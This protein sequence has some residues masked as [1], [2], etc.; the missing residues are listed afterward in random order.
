M[1]DRYT[2]LIKAVNDLSAKYPEIKG[3][4]YSIYFWKPNQKT[5]NIIFNIAKDLIVPKIKIPQIDRKVWYLI[6]GELP[7]N[8][9][10]LEAIVEKLKGLK[11]E[12]RILFYKSDYLKENNFLW[13]K[14][15]IKKPSYYLNRFEM[16][17]I[18]KKAKA[19]AK[20]YDK[21]LI[22]YS[23]NNDIEFPDLK[24]LEANLFLILKFDYLARKLI[25]ENKPRIIITSVNSGYFSIPFVR[26]ANLV[27]SNTIS[28]QHGDL[29]PYEEIDD[30]KYFLCWGD[31]FKEKIIK[32][33]IDEDK[34]I[35]IGSPRMDNILQKYNSLDE[36]ELKLKFG[37]S[38][39]DKIIL[40]ISDGNFGKDT[41][42]DYPDDLLKIQKDVFPRVFK[43]LSENYKIAVKLHPHEEKYYWQKLENENIRIFD[44]S[45]SIYELIK[46][47]SITSTVAS[48][49]G[50]EAMVLGKPTLYFSPDEIDLVDYPEKG[51]GFKVRNAEEWINLAEKLLNDNDFYRKTIDNI[52]IKRDNFISN[53]G[54]SSEKIAK[55]I[56][57]K[58]KNE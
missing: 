57:N 24:F 41:C 26:Y 35:P 40:H 53:L 11:I 49:A 29:G 50:F 44:P 8:Y 18:L 48:I 56:F 23:K 7:S 6:H 16:L 43:K 5:R 25:Y 34:I 12:G 52:L 46:I 14:V 9:L 47:S 27:N 32:R 3:T 37:F 4:F 36:N 19:I 1:E 13:G 15:E 54:C 17:R 51:L 21:C 2:H 31:Y 45:Y 39:N 42:N 55:F 10:N 38:Q 22:E 30:C 58:L 20:E 28:V 33:G